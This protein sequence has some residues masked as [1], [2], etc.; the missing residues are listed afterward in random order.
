VWVGSH[1]QGQTKNAVIKNTNSIFFA[2][3]FAGAVFD[4]M[5]VDNTTM[6]LVSRPQ[7]FDVMVMP[8]LYGNIIGRTLSCP[9]RTYVLTVYCKWTKP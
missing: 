6:Q 1:L 9:S 4:K 7:Q 8:N 3:W 2:N 5:I